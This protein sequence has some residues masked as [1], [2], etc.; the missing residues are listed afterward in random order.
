MKQRPR[1]P[2]TGAEVVA[3]ILPVTPPLQL[4]VRHPGP[5]LALL[6]CLG[7][8]ATAPLAA[9]FQTLETGTMRLVYTSPLQAY[10]VPQVARSFE[11]SLRFHAR[12]WDYHPEGKMEV[13]MHDLWHYGNAGARPVPDNHVTVGIE[14]YAHEYESGPAPERMGSSMNH[15][16]AHIFTVDK[17]TG[18]D[19]FWRS[20][21]F[22]K[23]TP[24]AEAPPSMLYSYLTTPRWYTP[25]WYL[26]GI[27]TYMETWMNGGLG[28][29]IGPYDEM[30]FRTMIRDS[31]RIYDLVGL[32]SEGTAID[33]QVGVNSYLYGTRFVSYLALRY[34]N[35]SLF[36]WVNRAPGSRAY[37][38]SQ[39]RKVYGRS[40]EAEWDRWI[41]WERDWQ[42]ANLEAIRQQPVSPVRPIT[43]RALGSVSRGYYD[44][45]GHQLYVALRYPGQ[46]A[47]LA[48]IDIATGRIRR[49]AT[50]LGASG[51]SVTSLAWDPAGRTLF[52][53]TNNADWRHLWARDLTTGRTRKLLH[54][55]R[56]GDLVFSPADRS[57]WGVRHDNGFSTI[58]RIPYPY[59]EW[60]QVQ[61]LPYGRDVFDLD[62]SPDGT[63]LIGSQGEVDGSLRLV[64]MNTAALLAGDT[65]RQVLFEFGHW[66]PSN[67][68]F[69]PDGKFLFGSSYY[70]GVSNIFRYDLERREMAPL[71]NAETGFFKPVPVSADSLLVF[72]FSGRG[73]LPS[74]IPNQ[75][76]ERVSAI[77]FLGNEIAEHRPEVQ[78]WMPPP[79]SLIPLDSL[80]VSTGPYRWTREFKLDNAYPIVEGYEDAAGRTTVAGGMRFNWSDR[81]GATSLDLTASWSPAQDSS[82]E[83]PHL[84]AVLRHWNWKV[85]AALNRA[86]FYDL[87]GP[88]K[89]S[90]R[91]Y[92]LGVQY[93]RTLLLDAPRSLTWTTQVAGYGDLQTQP[94]FQGVAASTDKL[95]AASSALAY[96]SLRRSLGAIHDELGTT[97]DLTLR[98]NRVNGT[99]YPRASLDLGKGFLLPVDHASLWVRAG[100][101]GRL[102]GDRADPNA[103]YFFGGFGNNWVDHGSIER[104]REPESFPGLE[105]NQVSGATYARAQVELNTP[106]LRFRRVGSPSFYLRWASLAVVA[107]G[108]VT[109]PDDDALQRTYGSLGA[110]ANFRFI[111]LSNM[112]STF[113]AGWA[114]AEG[115]GLPSRTE[116]MFSFKIM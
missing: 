11:N 65:T 61:T 82:Y 41:A 81:I 75:V 15:E 71:S 62:I 2:L 96:S 56:I 31:A 14:P 16:L 21:F 58:V 93:S 113:S 68:V 29:A 26:E 23:V 91:G 77:R 57:L 60:K 50:I 112:E 92:S 13:L 51:F 101:G 84:R 87:F 17:P 39:F 46:E 55:A 86:D 7:T 114:V 38:T 73:F 12:F 100:A 111:T 22:G 63:T 33:F 107:T 79:S 6:A 37:F 66:G 98:G 103:R 10:L 76:P 110:Q 70:S 4:K 44:P 9:Q 28:R 102:A 40:L 83:R 99:A 54:N 59:T 94:E 43:D 30:V 67:F 25:R 115:E 116:W 78:G 27:A 90:R 34:G 106:P 49:I 64:Q 45:A 47:A 48:A 32:E 74:M 80:T 97:W 104:Y 35:D 108:L 52:Y 69:S 109:D 1:H 105:I 19:R 89:L 95:L 85:Q 5:I 24:N 20:A 18:G 72:Q 8:W 53:T 3:Y 42:R 88:T 36:A